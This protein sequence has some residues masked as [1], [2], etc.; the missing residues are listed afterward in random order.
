MHIWRT[1]G[2]WLLALMACAAQ[3][4]VQDYVR[5][6]SY[7]ATPF[8]SEYSCR[9]SAID[10]VRQ[11]LVEE[12]GTYVQSV[13]K[14]HSNELGE[15]FVTQDMVTLTAG[16]ISLK[17]LQEDWN[18]IRYYV[19][20]KMQAD[21][22]EVLQSVRR[23]QQN[24][25]LEDALRQSQTALH[26]AREEI[27]ALRQQLLVAQ[28]EG[29][30]LQLASTY[31]A[32]LRNVDIELQFQRAM[33]LR[34]QGNFEQAFKDFRQ[35]AE[36][37]YARAQVRLGFM[38][39]RGL[40]IPADAT[41]A[42]LWY[43]K[44]VA[45]GDGDALARLGFMYERGIGTHRDYNRA[46]DY[47]RQSVN[48][49]SGFGMAQLGYL[50]FIGQGVQRDEIRAIDY[51]KQAAAKNSGLGLARL[52]QAYVKGTGVTRDLDQA[53]QLLRRA[54]E[55]GN[56]LGMAHLGD[57]YLEGEGVPQDEVEALRLF[58]SAALQTNPH[59]LAKLGYMYEEGR[60]GLEPDIARALELYRRAADL[61]ATFGEMRL[62][63]AYMKG[64]GV[65]RDRA[66]A[67]KWFRRAADKGH[68]RALQM[69]KKLE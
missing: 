47:Y 13:F 16:I 25:E 2:V 15:V 41:E 29:N 36:Q 45:L 7:T 55:N 6:Y 26:E 37:G 24:N 27:A 35:M 18:R 63:R 57:L 5:D 44:A 46:V 33:Q 65:P 49:G 21:P 38:Y 68:P 51:Y 12:L 32:M 60:G 14:S 48:R 30:R 50:Y 59:G 62:G 39:E 8:D 11:S 56:G 67:L 52:G 4:K 28:Q 43:G 64:I 42:I 53:A 66:E 9:I 1:G 69:V 54:A 23:L 40:G 22:D 20:A 19:Q 61:G 34:L 58:N 17:V 31:Q 10:G 3:A